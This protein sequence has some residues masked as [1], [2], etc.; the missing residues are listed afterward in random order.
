MRVYIKEG[1]TKGD[2]PKEAD[3]K[4]SVMGYQEEQGKQRH[5][6]VRK[7]RG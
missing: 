2:N 5:Y 6:F 4:K 7:Y 3:L 1:G